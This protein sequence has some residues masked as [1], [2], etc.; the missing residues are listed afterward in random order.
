LTRVPPHSLACVSTADGWSE[1][2]S[3]VFTAH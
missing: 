1:F 3:F 2:A